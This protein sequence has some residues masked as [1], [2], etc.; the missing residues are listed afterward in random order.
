MCNNKSDAG[1]PTDP[2]HSLPFLLTLELRVVPVNLLKPSLTISNSNYLGPE[3]SFAILF[4]RVKS[5]FNII[6]FFLIDSSFVQSNLSKSI[7]F[8]N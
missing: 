7:I 3:S 2:T 1:G 4:I 6:F 5:I 8:R